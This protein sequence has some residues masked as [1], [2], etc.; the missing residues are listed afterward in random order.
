MMFK[1]AAT[2]IILAA[3]LA[4]GA[5]A[6]DDETPTTPTTPPAPV[7]ETFSGNISQNGVSIHSF[8]TG[9]SGTV[10]ATLKTVAPDAALV[11]GFSLG[12]WNGTA[13][14]VIL[15]N[16]AAT[17]GAVLTGTMS[18]IGNLCLRMYDVGN[19]AAIPASYSVEIVHP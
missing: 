1:P 2:R 19:V 5:A 18:G 6:C 9:G 11:V 13:C 15:D 12:N 7:T 3:L 16:P 8:S 10:T 17:G 4:L 14:Q